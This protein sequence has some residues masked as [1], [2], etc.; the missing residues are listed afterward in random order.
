MICPNCG[1]NAYKANKTYS[2]K[3]YRTQSR[4]CCKC[5]HKGVTV[6]LNIDGEESAYKV[7]KRL[8]R[9]DKEK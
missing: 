1:E 7:L 5:Y 2:E 6:L 3:H 9:E 8:L 4:Q